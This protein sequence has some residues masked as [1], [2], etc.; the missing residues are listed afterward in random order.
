MQRVS[1]ALVLTWFAIQPTA[2]RAD[3]RNVGPGQTFA[4][5]CAAV[6]AASAGDVIEIAAGTYTDSCAITLAG[7][8]LRGMNG[9]PK[10]DLSGTDHPAQYKGIYVIAADDVTIENLELSGAHISADNGENAAALR[11]EAKGLTVRNCY[12]HD[13]QNGILGG[14]TGTLTIEYTDDLGAFEF[15]TDANP[16]DDAGVAGM[17]GGIGGSA[18]QGGRSASGAGGI[19]AAGGG[20]AS[21]RAGAGDAGSGG[22][23]LAADGGDA[24]SDDDSSGCSCDVPGVSRRAPP[25]VACL[26]LV[27]FCVLMRLGRKGRGTRGARGRPQAREGCRLAKPGFAQ[28]RSCIG[29]ASSEMH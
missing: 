9:R 3:T 17:G 8:T 22:R 4:T 16:D 1:I 7:L 11:V 27:S 25:S 13:N 29:A 2:L 12:L 26:C 23:M 24:S 28:K 6:A 14:T 19:V 20:G 10:I 15:V 5:P 21:G 18:A